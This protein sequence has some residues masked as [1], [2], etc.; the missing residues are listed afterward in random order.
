MKTVLKISLALVMSIASFGFSYAAPCSKTANTTDGISIT[1]TDPN[2]DCDRALSI[3]L[4][5]INTLEKP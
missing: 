5:I 4:T 1:V 2:G 3:L